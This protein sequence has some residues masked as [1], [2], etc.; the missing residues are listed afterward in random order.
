ML[1]AHL[2]IRPCELTAEAL[3]VIWHPEVKA[4]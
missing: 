4:T 1:S 3:D 2:E